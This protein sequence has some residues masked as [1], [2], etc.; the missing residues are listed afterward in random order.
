VEAQLFGIAAISSLIF[1]AACCI[2][3]GVALVATFVPAMQAARI[4]PLAAIRND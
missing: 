3:A 2:F 1:V 4:D